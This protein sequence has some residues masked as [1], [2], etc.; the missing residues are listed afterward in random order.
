M[1]EELDMDSEDSNDADNNFMG[2]AGAGL[3]FSMLNKNN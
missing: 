3:Q 2:E 1:N